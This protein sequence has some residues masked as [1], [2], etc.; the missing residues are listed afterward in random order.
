[1]VESNANQEAKEEQGIIKGM[2]QLDFKNVVV[3]LESKHATWEKMGVPAELEKG[4]NYLSYSK[5]SII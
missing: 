2:R 3:N 1:M 5:P 4:L